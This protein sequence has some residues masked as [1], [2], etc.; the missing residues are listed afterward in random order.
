MEI[1][2]SGLLTVPTCRIFL[3]VARS[4]V[5]CMDGWIIHGFL[6]T[7]HGQLHYRPSMDN[8]HGRP[9]HRPWET[10]SVY[11]PYSSSR[12]FLSLLGWFLIL[13]S[14]LDMDDPYGRIGDEL[15]SRYPINIY[16]ALQRVEHFLH[17]WPFFTTLLL[18]SFTKTD[19]SC[20][21]FSLL[22]LR[23]YSRQ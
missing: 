12:K 11:K 1:N 9:Y 15:I 18:N 4:F 8:V 5:H 3:S 10:S 21:A 6:I 23:S 16:H 20:Q 17:S 13:F 2:Y 14:L 19:I 7:I 22:T